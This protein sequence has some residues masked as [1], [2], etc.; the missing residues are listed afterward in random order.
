MTLSPGTITRADVPDEHADHDD[1]GFV[2]LGA[3]VRFSRG[4]YLVGE[5]S[6][7]ISGYDPNKAAWG[8]AIEMRT[9][10]HTMQLNFT[11][12]FGTTL[13]QI[14]RGGSPHD[15]YLGFNITRKF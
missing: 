7:R 5:Y 15:V 12:T 6:P 11:N 2:G 8:A 13:G 10:G 4:G 9:G 1:T 14:A 3:R